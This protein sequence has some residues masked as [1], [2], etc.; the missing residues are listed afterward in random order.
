MRPNESIMANLRAN[1]SRLKSKFY[2]ASTNQ[3]FPVC[4]ESALSAVISHKTRICPR[5]G[6]KLDKF[7]ATLNQYSIDYLS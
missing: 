7:V 4:C 2:P 6:H 3:Y 1:L 5:F